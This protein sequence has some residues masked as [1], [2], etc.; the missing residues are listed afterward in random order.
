MQKQVYMWVFTCL[1]VGM[2]VAGSW[3]EVQGV[4]GFE[5]RD[6]PDT[7]GVWDYLN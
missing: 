1:P 2:S 6:H 7:M 3:W 4:A 5:K